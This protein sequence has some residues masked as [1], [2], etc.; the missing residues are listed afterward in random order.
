MSSTRTSRRVALIGM[1]AM[2]TQCS[3]AWSQPAPAAVPGAASAGTGA[4]DVR[5][6]LEALRSKIDKAYPDVSSVVVMQRGELL[7]EH[8]QDGGD[9]DT[10]RQVQS[11][12][13]SVLALLVGIALDRGAIKSL[14]QP[15]ASL[16]P[17]MAPQAQGANDQPIT[18]RHLLTMTA[19]FEVRSDVRVRDADDPQRLMQ[20]PRRAPPGAVFE[21]DN[22][23]S[24]LLAIA[25]EAAVGQPVEAFARQVLFEPL[26]IAGFDWESGRNGHNL[27]FAGLSLRTRDMAR[28]G[29]LAL[30]QGTWQG[31]QLVPKE[32]TASAVQPQNAGG[33]PVGLAYGYLWWVSPAGSATRTFI[34]SGF[35]GQLVWVYPPLDLVVATTAPATEASNTRGQAMTLIRSDIFRALTSASKQGS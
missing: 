23:S 9:V 13:K 11:V 19:G 34:A 32:F 12:T 22:L 18:V 20:R 21:Y 10:L 4:G 6:S 25:L 26:G 24:N 30:Q 17:T 1:V 15:V 5:A 3:T 33:R 14:D 8:Y 27:G 2:C 29:Q 28:L 35:G 31:R 16:L 7:F